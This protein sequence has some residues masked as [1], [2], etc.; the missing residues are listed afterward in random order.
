MTISSR[1][2][3]ALSEHSYRHPQTPPRNEVEING[4][5]YTV[6]ANSDRPSG[7]QGT[8]YQRN[9]TGEIIVAHRGTE[10]NRGLREAYRDLVSTDA[11]MVTH[12][13]NQQSADAIALTQ[14][15]VD[16]AREQAAE[17]GGQAPQVTVT[18]HSLG[19]TLAQITANRFGLQGE[20]FNAYG[21][22]SLRGNVPEGGNS[23]INHVRATDVVSAGSAHFGQVRVYATQEDITALQNA[24]YRNDRS[25]WDLRNPLS[26]AGSRGLPAHELGP[27]IREGGGGPLMTPENQRRAEQFDP[28]IDKFRNDVEAIRTG[29]SAGSQGFRDGINIMRGRWDRLFTDR[30][31]RAD[32]GDGSIISDN[33]MVGQ[34]Y[35]A[36]ARSGNTGLQNA[37]AKTVAGIVSSAQ[38]GGL[39]E[40]NFI[41]ERN[42]T[43]Y[44]IQGRSPDDPGARVVPVNLAAAQVQPL[45]ESSRMAMDTPQG[46][47]E[48]AMARRE[49]QPDQQTAG[50]SR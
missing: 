46:Q 15:A 14:R 35:A 40:I 11:T 31:D 5:S 6:L 28:M 38:Q 47:P 9:D 43:A 21:A 22:A 25:G 34:T 41:A 20:T 30:M 16:I 27:F 23:V 45:A 10:P 4:V 44:A 13:V 50:M 17:R 39:N 7:Y 33:P 49:Q 32:I 2:Y 12:R 36:L 48:V 37:D 19:G 26:V 8:I 3:A 24:G 29:I 18:G 1:D 42:G